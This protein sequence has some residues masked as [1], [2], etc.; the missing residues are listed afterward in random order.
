MGFP[1][2]AEL[3]VRCRVKER[4]FPLFLVQDKKEKDLDGAG[5]RRKTS[6][7]EEVREM[8]GICWSNCSMPLPGLIPQCPSWYCWIFPVHP[9]EEGGHGCLLW[10]CASVLWRVFP[11]HT[12]VHVAFLSLWGHTH[13]EGQGAFPGCGHTSKS[14]SASSLLPPP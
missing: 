4:G 2:A 1:P 8:P 13:G 9:R 11:E 5:K 12:R 14:R 3:E 7:S 10:P 6:Q